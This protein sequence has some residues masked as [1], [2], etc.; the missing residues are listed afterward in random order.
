MKYYLLTST[1]NNKAVVCSRKFKTRNAAVNYMM[2]RLSPYAWLGPQLE[3]ERPIHGD[4]HNLEY[5][6]DDNSRFVVTR[7]VVSNETSF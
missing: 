1:I 6:C 4:K 3:I 5:I 7:V 2:S